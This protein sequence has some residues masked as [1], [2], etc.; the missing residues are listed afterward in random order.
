MTA[1]PMTKRT[2]VNPLLILLILLGIVAL[3]SLPT[4]VNGRS[5]AVAKHG[6]VIANF[7]R[8]CSSDGRINQLWYSHQR[9]THAEICEL[10]GLDEWWEQDKRW[11]VR[12]IEAK[13]R[14]EITVFGH[15]GDYKSLDAYLTR[16]QYIF[17]E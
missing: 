16:Q 1:L 9:G 3:A 10:S 17:I 5:H 14:E 12:V 8:A 6:A 7:A 4:I 15:T 11:T 13:S 2:A